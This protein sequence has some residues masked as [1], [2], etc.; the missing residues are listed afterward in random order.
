MVSVNELRYLSA[1]RIA[2]MFTPKEM[3][4]VDLEKLARVLNVSVLPHDFKGILFND[5][6]VACA[7]VTNDKGNSCVFYSEEFLARTDY[8]ARMFIVKAFAKYIVT[9]E[10]NFYMTGETK[11]S[12]RE[13]MLAHEMLAPEEQVRDV[14]SRLIIPTTYALGEIF[15]VSQDFVRER[16][17]EIKLAALIAGYNYW[18]QIEGTENSVPFC[19]SL[20]EK[21][22]LNSG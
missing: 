16:L 11:L 3:A 10:N 4:T 12:N 14:L 21:L 6:K 5:E 18:Q 13:K 22:I 9:G 19:C 1:P 20:F 15:Q 7:F 17:S 8:R 2:R